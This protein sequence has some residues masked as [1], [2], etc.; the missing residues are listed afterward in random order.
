MRFYRKPKIKEEAQI[1]LT[2]ML[3][4]IFIMLIFFIV[5]SSFATDQALDISRPHAEHANKQETSPLII[6]INA[7]NEILIENR[8]IDEKLIVNAIIHY[9]KQNS[10]HHSILIQADEKAFNGTVVKVI[11]VAK[12][13]GVDDVALAVKAN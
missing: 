9:K 8:I 1:D 3:D 6:A 5:T 4:I 10:N 12:G 2:S 13:Q 11:D 7:K